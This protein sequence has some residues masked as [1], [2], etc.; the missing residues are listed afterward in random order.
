MR[1]SQI[2]RRLYPPRFRSNHFMSTK[3]G[4]LDVSAIVIV[5]L[6]SV[7]SLPTPDIQALPHIA[8]ACLR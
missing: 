5:G 4:F 1:A 7:E 6:Q 8:A 3:L 2:M